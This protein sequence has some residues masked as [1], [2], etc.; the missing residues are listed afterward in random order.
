MQLPAAP[1]ILHDISLHITSY[2]LSTPRC[3]MSRAAIRRSKPSLPWSHKQ[4]FTGQLRC[5]QR[6]RSSLPVLSEKSTLSAAS[7]SATHFIVDDWL[8]RWMDASSCAADG[9]TAGSRDRH[10]EARARRREC[11]RHA[12]CCDSGGR[13]QGY[14]CR[15]ALLSRM[16]LIVVRVARCMPELPIGAECNSASHASECQRVSKDHVRHD[17]DQHLNYTANAASPALRWQRTA[18]LTFS[19]DQATSTANQ[20][21]DD[22]K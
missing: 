12:A 9:R 20:V 2:L 16:S 5:L 21:E 15:P 22:D 10:G 4:C 1:V 17:H 14:G 3:A 18:L 6:V 13:S 8:I 19:G 11:P 7:A